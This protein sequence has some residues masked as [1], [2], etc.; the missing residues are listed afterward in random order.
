MGLDG[1]PYA[2]LLEEGSKPLELVFWAIG[3]N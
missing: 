3:R 2:T 1:T